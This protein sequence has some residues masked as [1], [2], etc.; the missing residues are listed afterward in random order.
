[1]PPTG[2]HHDK[3]KC[4]VRRPRRKDTHD[5]HISPALRNCSCQPVPCLPEVR[6]A[7]LP[8]TCVPLTRPCAWRSAPAS[9]ACAARLASSCTPWCAATR[10]EL[11]C[12]VRPPAKLRA[13]TQKCSKIS[14]GAAV[15]AS[16]RTLAPCHH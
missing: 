4:K 6:A 1:M 10:Y 5:W 9:A 12:G 7:R 11:P 3:T 16:S 2:D 8:C 13:G 15:P 14:A